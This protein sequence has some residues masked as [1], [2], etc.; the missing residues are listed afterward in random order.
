MRNNEYITDLDRIGILK[1]AKEELEIWLGLYQPRKIF[2]MVTALETFEDILKRDKQRE[3]DEFPRKVKFKR[4][5]IGPGKIITVPYV[6]EE[7]L[8]HGDFEPKR[9][10][11]LGQFLDNYYDNDIT[12]VPGSG[13]GETGDVIDEVPLPLDG[14]EEGEEGDGDGQSDAGNEPGDHVF[15]EDAHELGKRLTEELKLPNLTNKKKKFLTDEYTYDL[16][17]RHRGSGQLLDKKETLKRIVK[18]N[19]ILGRID[20]DNLDPTKMIVSPQD[21]VYRVLSRERVWKSQAV[22]CFLRDYSG[23]M[24]GEPTEALVAQ[25]LLIY[26]WL[27]VQYE[28]R[29]IPR[30]F[31]HDTECREVTARQYFGLDASGGTLIA[32]GYKKINEIVEGE[33]L[34]EEYDIFVFQGGDG[35]D[36]DHLGEQALPELEKI[37][38]YVSRM[39]VTIFKNRH[40]LK[41]GIETSFEEYI[42]AAGIPDFKDVFRMHIMPDEDVTEEMNIEA[43]K[44]LI[45]QD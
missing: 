12:I 6:E 10:V 44:V 20:K 16:T 32:S 19:L 1:A 45:A 21:R 31:V 2:G 28:K 25:H 43:L 15:E 9:I 22:V 42:N 29:V 7:H 27:L 13:E 36:W 17:D 26:S 3:D 35:D 23:S 30:F 33:G 34:S 41:K 14:G 38:S 40:Y 39:G 4:I 37:L 11:E 5:L 8:S 24:W 18:T